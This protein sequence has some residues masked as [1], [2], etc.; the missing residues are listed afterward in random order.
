LQD[1]RAALVDRRARLDRAVTA[2]LRVVR[3]EIATA[4]R[5]LDALSPYA[6]LERGYGHITRR[7]DGRTLQSVADALPGTGLSVRLI[8][9]SFPAVVE[10]QPHLLPPEEDT[11]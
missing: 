6:T 7:A 8:D 11:T 1:Q 9:G 2:W 3:A 10:G 5:R 4:Q